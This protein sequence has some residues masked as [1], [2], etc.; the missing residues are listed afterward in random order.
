[1]S[2]PTKKKKPSGFLRTMAF[3][4]IW[5]VPL[6]YIAYVAI[7]LT[8][9]TPTDVDSGRRL[10]F[11]AWGLIVLVILLVVYV[12]NIRKRLATVIQVSEIQN[13]PVPAFWRF[14][15]LVEYAVSF[16][17]LIGAVYVINALSSILYTFGIVSLISGTIGYVL[18]MIDSMI[19]E[20]HY[21]E[22][23]LLNRG[24]GI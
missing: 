16:G 9:T 8:A 7:D 11:S 5:V 3:L 15:Q 10:V 18:L 19:R 14:I 20:K 4:L 6:S 17:L 12:I 22:Q 1:M 21:Q 24:K 2:K 23:Q 13:R